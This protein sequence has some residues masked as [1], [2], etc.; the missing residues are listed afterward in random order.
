MEVDFSDKQDEFFA[1]ST[2]FINLA[3]GAVRSGKTYVNLYRF[4]EHALTAPPGDMMILGKTERTVKRNAISPLKQIARGEDFRVRYVQG[5]GELWINERMIHVVG[6]ND[7]A[8]QDKI[9]GATL[10]GSYCNELTLYPESAWQTLIDR[11][12]IDGAKIFADCNPN[13]PYHWLHKDYMHGA[14]VEPEDMLSLHFELDD[15]PNL[16]NEYKRRI[17]RLHPPGTLWHKRMVLGEWVVAE[18]AIY[19][20]WDENAHVVDEMPGIPEKVGIGIDVGTQNATVFIAF[21]KV[22]DTWYAFDEYYHSGRESGKQKTN[23]EYA[24]EFLRFLQRIGY[25]PFTI[26][27]DPSAADFKLELRNRGV[28]RVHD[29]DNSV[30]EGIRTVS[31]ALTGGTLKVL[32]KVENLR[33]EFPSYVWDPKKQ[34]KGEDAPLKAGARDHGLDATRYFAMRVLGKQ[35]QRALRLVR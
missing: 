18:G 1:T 24:E 14:A 35:P 28:R 26:E 3:E 22:G 2:S 8:A 7:V 19:E 12:S 4:A 13:S 32:R 16:S 25:T 33:S 11:H 30:V 6:A 29:A 23:G 9:Q 34:E 31:T 10:A 27:V 21:G 20:Q 5:A 17:H 15:N